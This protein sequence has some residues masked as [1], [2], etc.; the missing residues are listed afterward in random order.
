MEKKLKYLV[1]NLK[2]VFSLSQINEIAKTSKFV[3]RQSGIT[4]KDFLIFNAFYGDNICGIS[5]SQLASKYDAL[6]DVEVSRQALDKRFNDYSVTFMKEIF[7]NLMFSQNTI[8]KNLKTTLNLHF[9]RIIINDS[10]GFNLP[11]EFANEFAGSGGSAS[12][13][14][15]KIQLQYEL[16]SGSF[17]RLDIFSGTN[18]D[19]NYL[20]IMEIDKE[21]G[22]LKLADLGYLK[23]DYLKAL[24]KSEASFISKVKSNTALYLKNLKPEKHK[25]GKI[26]KTSRYKKIDILELS[27]PLTE[28][29]TIELKD[30]YIG[31]KKELKTR[32]IIT[33]L[34]EENKKKREA[35]LKEN[36]RK[37]C[38]VFKQKRMDF[39]SVN[40]YITNVDE[41]ILNNLQVH[42]LYTLRWQIEIMIK[43]WKSIFKINQVKKVKIE[44]FKCFLYGRLIALLLSSAIAFTSKNIVMA[45][46]GKEIS[47]FQSFGTIFQYFPRLANVIFKENIYILN[48]LKKIISNFKKFCLKTNKN[49]KKIPIDILKIIELNLLKIEKI[50]S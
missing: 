8:L 33:K 25:N 16:L 17:M 37:K 24:D 41:S 10:T 11:K 29:E 12:S 31:S 36:I 20:D 2:N 35:T 23:V 3:Q 13:S 38:Q 42:E 32:L 39:N 46:D 27:K 26:K 21:R 5:L 40:A 30:V 18:S 45:T 9:N 1:K 19:A 49:M 48:L 6:F 43:I 22:D 34:T 15:I 7:N 44:R 47:E 14:A 4:A 28:G 50:A